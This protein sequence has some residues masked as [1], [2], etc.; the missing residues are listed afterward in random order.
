[1]IIRRITIK[2]LRAIKGEKTIEFAPGLNLIKGS[3]NE[4]G[5][6]SLRIAITKA[7]FQD[8]TTLREEIQSLTSWGTDEPWEVSLRFEDDSKSYVIT[9]NYKDKVG[10]LVSEGPEPF[11]A[12]NKN[13]ISEKIRDITGCPDEAFFQST[14]CIG[15]EELIRILPGAMSPS[16]R[17]RAVVTIDSRLQEKISGTGGLDI[18]SLIARLYAQTHRKEAGGPY[19]YLQEITERLAE[20]RVQKEEQEK[21]VNDILENRRKLYKVREE[22]EEIDQN[23]PSKQEVILK[24]RRILELN[25]EISRAK[26]RY[27]SFKKAKEFGGKLESLDKEVESSPFTGA[28]ERIKRLD[29]L[30]G[31][32]SS[33]SQQVT[34]FKDE[35]KAALRLRPALWSLISG[36]ILILAGLTGLLLTPLAV[37]SVAGLI[38]LTYWTVMRRTSKKQMNILERKLAAAEGELEKTVEETQ[39]LLAGF[40][41]RSYDEYCQRL[42]EYSS[43]VQERKDFGATLDTLLAGKDWTQYADENAEIDIEISAW[44]KELARLKPF[45]LEP[46]EL[47]RLE[48]EVDRLNQRRSKLDQEKGALER[49]LEYTDTD[50]DLLTSIEEELAELIENKDFWEKRKKVYDITREMLGDAHRQTMSSASELL[51]KEISR[52]IS[53]ITEGRYTRVKM[54]E[55]D[56]S[57]MTFSPEKDDWVDVS[58]LSRATQDQFY[59]CARFA[60]VKLITEGRKPPLLLD[61]P[62]VNFHIIR[63]RNIIYLLQEIAKENQILLFTCSDTYDYLGKV[64]YVD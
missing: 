58:Y 25:E 39:A 2:R 24:N 44:L 30:E 21:K 49:F 7:L 43:K 51:E 56:L 47:Q 26:A 28:A 52:Y 32:S 36:A 1:M 45:G 18:Q 9:K 12:K 57:L 13:T 61:D 38:L 64:I 53:T 10:E 11:V 60:L 31:K 46:V 63:L 34:G 54:S 8:P 5:K 19:R 62:F 29:I 14:A 50:R 4:A 41:C 35:L 23:L 6:T 37:V 42:E 33:L 59:L 55:K 15:Q 16:E 3:N 48:H 20:L 17:Q 22:Q 40:G 27:E